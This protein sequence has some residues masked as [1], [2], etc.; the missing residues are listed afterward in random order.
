MQKACKPDGTKYWEYIL[1]YVDDMLVISHD[2]KSVMQHLES[3][4]T[5]KESSVKEPD[6]YLGTWIRKFT[7]PAGEAT[8][9]MSS[10]LYIARAIADVEQELKRSN[11]TLRPRVTTPMS[12]RYRPK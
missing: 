3:K 9:A 4:Y 1:C 7:L 2:P 10:D 6:E 11:Q 12:T 8:W 5:L